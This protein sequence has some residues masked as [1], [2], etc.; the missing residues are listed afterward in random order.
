MDVVE[1]PTP[2]IPKAM[3]AYSAQ[4]TNRACSAARQRGFGRV[5]SLLTFRVPPRR[6]ESVWSISCL[7]WRMGWIF[8]GEMIP[9]VP[10]HEQHT[11]SL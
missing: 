8:S 10:G 9:T 11:K 2:G 5:L 1:R 4:L 7:P 6:Y 3:R